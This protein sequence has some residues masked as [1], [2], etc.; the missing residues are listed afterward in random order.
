[1]LLS[2]NVDGIARS[3]GR[4][5][6]HLQGRARCREQACSIQPCARPTHGTR[7]AQTTHT[8]SDNGSNEG[9]SLNAHDRVRVLAGVPAIFWGRA[10]VLG[11]HPAWMVAVV[12]FIFFRGALSGVPAL[13]FLTYWASTTLLV[14][15]LAGLVALRRRRERRAGYTTGWGF[16]PS[17]PQVDWRTGI[18]IRAVGAP[19]PSRAKRK[20]L[21]AAVAEARRRLEDEATNE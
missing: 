17:V 8:G 14:L 21:L 2:Q 13:V 12:A 11:V 6:P 1:M 5:E 7:K 16:D 3:R 9:L 20:A 10:L 18:I 4:C 19:Q 15:V